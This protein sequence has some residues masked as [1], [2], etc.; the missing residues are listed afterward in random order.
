MRRRQG[1][2]QRIPVADYVSYHSHNYVLGA[3]CSR[4]PSKTYQVSK[5]IQLLAH[6]TSPLPPPR[7]FSIHKV[8]EQTE[9]YEAQ[10]KVE[11]GVVERVVL[12]AVS[13]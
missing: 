6:E 2:R 1:I 9:R 5:R 3:G 10:R 4:R 7:N 13:E 12:R 11:I 8:E